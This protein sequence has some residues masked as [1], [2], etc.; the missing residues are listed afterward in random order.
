MSEIRYNAITGDWVIIA[1]ERSKRPMNFSDAAAKA[2][3]PEYLATCPFCK[4]NEHI[5]PDEEFRISDEEAGWRIRTVRNKFSALSF[6]GEPVALNHTRRT[7]NGVG[8][9]EVIIES[10][11][12]NHFMAFHSV[13][14][15]AGLL[16]VYRNR[17]LS[18]YEDQRVKHVILYKNHGPEAGTSLE[19][20]HSQIVG[21]P[22]V[23][24]Q[25]VQRIELAERS[26]RETG[27]CLFCSTMAEEVEEQ[28]RLVAETEHFVAFIPFASLSPYH[29]WIFPKVHSACFSTICENAMTDLASLLNSVLGKLYT[30]LHNPSYNF[31]IRSLSPQEADLPYFH[32]YLAIVPRIAKAAGFELG[33][34]MYINSSVP[35]YSAETLRAAASPLS[36]GA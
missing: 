5:A 4:G 36:A 30:A 25:V 15:T 19:H 24:G 31:V 35:E 29:V 13:Q 1:V 22:V 32:W 34:G 20:P 14:E 17:F 9:H 6:T 11:L 21:T 3:I 26:Y 7:I 33:T 28:K 2:N 23:P 18:Y 12:H 27:K 16:S 10:P 8:R